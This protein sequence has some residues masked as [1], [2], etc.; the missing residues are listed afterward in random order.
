MKKLI[1]GAVFGLLAACGGGGGGDDDVSLD[2][3]ASGGPDAMAECNPVTN[4]GCADGEKCTWLRITGAPNPLGRIACVA[5]GDK[6]VGAAC[7]TGAAGEATGFDDCTGGNI[8]IGGVCEP[9]C[10]L[11]NDTCPTGKLCSQYNIFANG[12]DTPAYGACDDICDPGTQQTLDGRAACGGS[13]TNPRGCYG[14]F[15]PV[16]N[17]DGEFTCS[18]AGDE[19]NVHDTAPTDLFLNV[20][21]PGYVLYFT[22]SADF[23]SASGVIK[24]VATC[25]PGPTN[26][27][28]TANEDGLVGG[29]ATCHGAPPAG[30]GVIGANYECKYM[31][32]HM[33]AIP[34]RDFNKNGVCIDPTQWTLSDL[35]G[36]PP[37]TT[38]GNPSVLPACT[39]LT[40]D[41]MIDW[42]CAGD[43]APFS[44]EEQWG[45]K[46][47]VPAA[48]TGSTVKPKFR[49]TKPNI[50][51]VRSAN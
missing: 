15:F 5:D 10:S 42:D 13:D 8:C 47:F 3:D 1:L 46:D 16:Q 30:R 11:A 40:A 29:A 51:F 22:T 20:C 12:T 26:S 7:T 4:T 33:N 23:A 44:A 14:L 45:C 34:D 41:Q 50:G 9:V 38:C 27:G 37:D 32:W 36:T 21:A 49:Q 2:P 35:Y 17:G 28:A 43:E 6:A 25:Q 48:L 31:H 39:S 19:A 24:C 18:P